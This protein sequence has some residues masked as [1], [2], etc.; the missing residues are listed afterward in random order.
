LS[1]V[2]T[3]DVPPHT[4]QDYTLIDFEFYHKMI[5]QLK[6]KILKETEEKLNN[7]KQNNKFFVNPKKHKIPA[8]PIKSLN[9]F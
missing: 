3:L 7:L 8:D 4:W 2:I 1:F 6:E 5:L 9:S